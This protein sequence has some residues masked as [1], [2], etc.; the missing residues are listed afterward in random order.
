MTFSELLT[1]IRL[2][3][4]IL[5]VNT[6]RRVVLWSPNQYVPT[7]TRRAIAAY[8]QEL[9]VL[10]EQSRIE[11]CANPIW[12]RK[13]WYHAGQQQYICAICQR[14]APYVMGKRSASCQ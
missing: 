6:R 2:H 9:C 5:R 3:R 8:N 4:L 7:V 12:H 10:I 1:Q 14:F 13:E 11:V